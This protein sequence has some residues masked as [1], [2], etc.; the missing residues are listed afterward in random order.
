MDYEYASGQKNEKEAINAETV[1]VYARK[2]LKRWWVILL[3]AVVLAAVGFTIAQLTYIPYYSSQIMFV[4]SNRNS[5]LVTSGQSSS[6][7]NAAVTLAG[8]FQ[9][10]FTTTEL[11]Q[12]VADNCGYKDISADD[13][14]DFISV[15]AVEDTTILYLTATTTDPDV[16]YAIANTYMEYYEEAITNAFPSTTLKAID[17]PNRPDAP[18]RDNSKI[19]YTAGGF[20]LGAAL[21]VL[22]LLS[23]MV[24]KDTVL[25]ADDIRQK[26][27]LKIIGSVVHV[28]YKTKKGEKRSILITDRRSGFAFI[29]SFKMIRTK[30]NNILLRKGQ[31]AIVVTSTL[32]NE[33]KTTTAINIALALAK[34]GKEVLL[35]DG[36]LRKP[37]VSKALGVSAGDAAG[38]A[39]VIS[40]SR[41]LSDAIRYSEKY[42][43]YLLLSG[44]ATVD[45]AELLSSEKMEEI[46]KTAKEEFDYVI[47]DTAPCG[48]VADAAVLAGYSDAIIMVVRQD[49]APVRRILRGL[50]N[51]DNSGTE[52]IGCVYN[53]AKVGFVQSVGY[54]K[55][56]YG[57]GYGYGAEHEKKRS[58]N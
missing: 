45:S 39:E 47:I 33:G 6:D 57:Y 40:G 29:E 58:S 25:N 49:T 15:Q 7:I 16:S 26:L 18:N 20:L 55:Y 38:L 3:S 14:K 8:N 43:L 51:M 42:N 52:I 35:I 36:D 11:S 30:L 17:P 9:Y 53:D 56:G 54:G 32:E 5:S 41:Q 44:P 19:L 48:E 37:V 22:V 28:P 2:L 46:I 12:R 21:S 1:L 4:A 34:N 50:E 23:S 24:F 27:G 13:V 31:K 10:V